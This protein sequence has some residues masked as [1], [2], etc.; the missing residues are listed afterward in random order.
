[1]HRSGIR[2]LFAAFIL[3]LFVGC[4]QAT[5]VYITVYETTGNITKIPHASVY[6]NGALAG[7]TGPEGNLTVTSGGINDLNLSVTKPGYE[8]WSGTAGVNQTTVLVPLMRKNLSLTVT[9]YDA[10]TLSPLAGAEVK[11]AGENTTSSSATDKNGTAIFGVKA[12]GIYILDISSKNYLPRT[13]IIE[14]DINN[15]EVQYALFRDD[16][17]S[18]L[19][20]SGPD[21]SPVA[22]AEIYIDGNLK[23]STDQRGVLTF[24]I[25]RDKVYNIKVKKAGYEDYLIKALISQNEAVYTVTLG[26][27]AY[28]AFVSVYNPDHT[29]VPGAQVIINGTLVGSTN[30]YGRY[31]LEGLLSGPYKVEVSHEGFVPKELL[32]SVTRQGEEINVDLSY[33]QV[34]MSVFVEDTDKKVLPGTVISLNG[35]PA[36]TTDEHGLLQARLTLNTLYNISASK[37]GYRTT[38]LQKQVVPGNTTATLTVTLEKNFD[39]LPVIIGVVIVGAVIA[40]AGVIL[41]IR[42][43]KPPQ[44]H[45]V[46]KDEI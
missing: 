25:T 23:G 22:D 43:K 13:A 38:S 16:R 44:V 28:Q 35:I 17:F 18:L 7:K 4:A 21:Q 19:V 40:A 15:K 12:E 9:T 36:G 26:K 31:T 1:M 29:P 5:T 34:N 46:R 33:G 3:L 27:A 14:M 6:V 11:V 2:I 41:S 24:D 20:K 42:R 10:D 37:E 39:W 30:Q 8:V 32:V 45:H